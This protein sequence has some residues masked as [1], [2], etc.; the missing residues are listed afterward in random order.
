M[1][2]SHIENSKL[3]KMAMNEIRTTFN[4][5]VSA[6]FS[7]SNTSTLR[8]K[9]SD[10]IL[11]KLLDKELLTK[12]EIQSFAIQTMI[13]FGVDTKLPLAE[14]VSERFRPLVIEFSNDLI[15]EY[16]CITQG[17]KAL[18]QVVANAFI[19]IIEFSQTLHNWRNVE[20]VDDQQTRHYSKIGKELDRA[21]RQFVSAIG[22]LKL[23]KAS[24]IELNVTANNA[25][26]AENQQINVNKNYN[27]EN[28]DPK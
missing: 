17:E 26:I 6:R 1:S 4:E 18:A 16:K 21:N 23:M 9:I 25:F 10:K 12:K 19:R 5:Y 28:I 11:P 22:T 2:K 7:G 20:F 3:K 27:L 14:S 24:S 8:K 15:E 13:R